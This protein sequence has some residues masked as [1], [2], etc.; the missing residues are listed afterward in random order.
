MA[1]K[2]INIHRA[3][4][5]N[6][7]VAIIAC[8][9]QLQSSSSPI[10]MCWGYLKT[11][12]LGQPSE[13]ENSLV[14]NGMVHQEHFTLESWD[15]TIL[16]SVPIQSIWISSHTHQRCSPTSFDTKAASQIDAFFSFPQKQRNYKNLLSL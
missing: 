8:G 12:A 2:S 6:S 15:A 11:T 7:F 4:G 9:S 14:L 5:F 1:R 3:K 16:L 13:L 10:M